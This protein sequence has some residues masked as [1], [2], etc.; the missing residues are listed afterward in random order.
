MPK[1]QKIYNILILIIFFTIVNSAVVS[2]F[3][4]DTYSGEPLAYT[5]VILLDNQDSIKYGTASDLEGYFIIPD[6]DSGLYTIRIMLIGYVINNEKIKIKNE[7]FRF[8]CN[9]DP[10]PIE[11]SE[12]KVSAER[13]RFEERV[14]VSRVNL[15]NRDIKFIGNL[16]LSLNSKYKKGSANKNLEYFKNSKTLMVASTHDDEEMQFLPV[17]E[18]L[19]SQINNLKII[20]APRHPERAISILSNY[21]KYGISAKLIENNNFLK[22]DVIIVDTFGNLPTYFNVS[23]IVFLGGSLVNKGGH[24]PIEPAINDCVILTGPYIHNWENIYYEM[25]ENKACFVFDKILNLEK[26]I[27][28]LFENDNEIYLLKEKSKKLAQKNFFDSK[29]LIYSIKNI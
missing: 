10:E 14:D 19:L 7:N 16:K 15:T 23:D 13:M 24:N 20:I 2:G 6:V 11:T 26:K 29:K 9:L 12:V 5:H 25:L 27:K 17:I 21:Q 1:S 18:R 4:K 22:E 8:N 28:N 3:I